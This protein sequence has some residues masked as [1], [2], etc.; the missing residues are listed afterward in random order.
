MIRIDTTITP[1]SLVR[2]TNQLFEL[3]ARKVASISR[4]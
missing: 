3:S 2:P 4:P 1:K